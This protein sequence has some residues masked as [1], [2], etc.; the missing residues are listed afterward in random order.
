MRR[1]RANWV[2]T[3]AG[4]L[5]LLAAT[6]YVGAQHR[7]LI[8]ATLDADEN[9]V[10]IQQEFNYKNSSKDTL[11]ILYFNDWANSYA[12]KRTAL[13]ARF[14]EDFNRSLHLAKPDDRGSTNILGLADEEFR[15]LQWQRTE[16][17][18]LIEISLA[19]PLP[20]GE[21]VKLYFTYTV[22]LPPARYTGY[23]YKPNGGFYLKDWYISPAV[24]D[25]SWQLYSN[26]NLEDLY[27]DNVNTR[28]EFVYPENL[29][30]G[31]NFNEVS[32]AEFSDR[33]QATLRG[34][35]RKNCEIILNINN[36][37]VKHVTPFLIV[38]TDIGADKY[39]EISQ[40]ISIHR[41]T[42]FIHNY[43][44][45]FPY[46]QLLVS[47]VDFEKNPLYGLNQLPSFI[48]PYDE[49]F[50]FEMKFLKTALRSYLKETIFLNPRKD[51]W[52]NDAIVNYIMINFVEEFYPN[53]KLLG[54]LSN[55]WGLRTF[56]LAKMSFNDQYPFL[57]M[58]TAR[59][60]ADQAL[61]TSNDSLIK[62]NQK[63]ANKYK[64]GLGLAYLADYIGKNKVDMGIRQFFNQ[65][66]LQPV[67]PEDFKN[68][69]KTFAITDIDWFFDIY[70]NTDARIDFKITD[71][72]KTDDSLTVTIKNKT[73]T[74]VPISLFGINNDTVVSEYW[75]S[76]ITDE[77][78]VKIPRLNEKRLVLNYDQKIPEF[79]QRDNWKSLNGFFSSNKK[80]KFQFLKDAED[81]Y[82]N[83]IF[84]MPVLTF[85][86]YD[87]LTPGLRLTNKTL[88]QRPFIF[89]FS[90]SYAMLENSLVGYGRLNFRDYHRKS[91]HYV[92]N[93]ALSGS[94][95]HFQTNS[96]YSTFTPS[97][98]FG[99][100][101]DNLISNRRKSLVF[102][103]I[104]VFR[105]IDPSLG[106]L[107]TDP[108]YSVL[109]VRYSDYHNHIIDYF[110]WFVDGQYS[111]NFS[112]ISF[113]MEYR[114]LFQ[115]NRQLNLRFFLGTFLKNETNSDFFS[116][117]L[118]RPTDYLFD[119][120]YLGRSESSGLVSQQIIIAEGGFKSQLPDPFADQWLATTNVSFNLWRWIELY[121]DVGFLK[122]KNNNARFLYDSGIRLNL[123]TDYFEL[124]FPLYSNNGWEIAQ[125]NY[126][127]KIRFVVTL[128]PKTLIGL[129]TRRWF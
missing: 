112:K 58:L 63:I 36:R 99:W 101:P 39:D 79:N 62:F 72:E 30:L 49:Q 86:V 7:N 3:V 88:L 106:D 117:A 118:D 104:N 16:G 19:D 103:Y 98:G 96:R 74:N 12:D 31:T 52:I 128:S 109:N 85:N 35:N 90:P 97:I 107:D 17:L 54:K 84:Y 48:R 111:N 76:D 43:L 10:D 22:K 91:G 37:F 42:E 13:A 71:V 45:P 29:L 55:I 80:L 32:I 15:N 83:Q 70:V 5:L 46:E 93:Y 115:N 23:G 102:R 14:A 24:Y 20:P 28:I 1:N 4:S 66:K 25:G 53:Q 113:N 95:Y 82:V 61:S 26:K 9:E 6:Q 64:A 100:R 8:N 33:K 41:I 75:F 124:Y 60:N 73:G 68:A 114:K 89:D 56:H 81:P 119:Y 77:K 27:T 125:P 108:D 129:F 122:R 18:D 127:Q 126:D 50:Q 38:V 44:G 116:F 21:E 2:R 92:T 57:Y 123:V 40:G 78:T 59:R 120:N 34:E 65:Y 51:H 47:E 69:L 105:D 67:A 121:G 94:S 11:S 110:G 87:G